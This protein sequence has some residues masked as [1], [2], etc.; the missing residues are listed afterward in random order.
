ML[1][2][3]FCVWININHSGGIYL[4]GTKIKAEVV[5]VVDG[6]TITVKGNDKDEKI[7]I[8]ALDTEESWPGG[9]KPMTPWGKKAKEEA[10]R[11]FTIG[12]T[13]TLEFPG[14]EAPDIC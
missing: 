13:V 3:D 7:R 9:D 8:L 1:L 10:Q 5:K 6:D 14:K 2:F 11:V 4:G 12:K